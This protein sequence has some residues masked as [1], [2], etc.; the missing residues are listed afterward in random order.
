MKIGK[1]RHLINIEES[2][3]SRDSFGGEVSEWIQFAEVWADVSPVS[4]REFTSFKQLNSEITTKITIRYL[5]GISTEMRILF[6]DRIF[7]I[8]SV[9]NPEERNISLILMCKEVV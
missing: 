4:G 9:I 1:L 5:E 7:E 2:R 3:V 8:E 6:R